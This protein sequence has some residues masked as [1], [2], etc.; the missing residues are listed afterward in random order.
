MLTR[1]TF[2][3]A[4]VSLGAA[5]LSQRA[6]GQYGGTVTLR[7]RVDESVRAA[8]PPLAQKSLTIEPDRSQEARELALRSPPERAIPIIFIIAGAMAV[9]MVL[10]MIR[11]ALRQTYYGGIIIDL[12]AQPPSVMNDPKIPGNMVFVIETGGKTTRYTS[13]QLSPELIGTLLK[14]K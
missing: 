8:I 1:R 14:A 11:E 4:I 7:M 9:P 12:R 3:I 10:Q 6:S 2:H 5:A 13:D